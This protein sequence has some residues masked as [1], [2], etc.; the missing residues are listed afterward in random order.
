[1]QKKV[2]S[3]KV[4]GNPENMNP[5][6][7]WYSTNSNLRRYVEDYYNESIPYITDVDLRNDIKSLYNEGAFTEKAQVLTLLGSIK[8][9]QIEM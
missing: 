8:N 2:I 7:L 4:F 6:N 9:Y 5:Y 3:R 1:M